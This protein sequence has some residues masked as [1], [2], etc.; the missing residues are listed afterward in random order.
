MCICPR[1]GRS[2]RL[3]ERGGLLAPRTGSEMRSALMRPAAPGMLLLQSPWG[4]GRTRC[5][6]TCFGA[7][8]QER[9]LAFPR[10][11]YV[12]VFSSKL[13]FLHLLLLSLI[14]TFWIIPLH[15]VS[16]PCSWIL[17]P[18]LQQD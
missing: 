10:Y 2:H 12:Q 17:I 1:R 6:L 15:T 18:F 14:K 16:T 8:W 4:L 7:L 3:T 9:D 5:A 11:L 13:I